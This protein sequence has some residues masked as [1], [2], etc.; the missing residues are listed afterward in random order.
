MWLALPDNDSKARNRRIY[1]QI[2]ELILR[3]DLK[4]GDRLPSTRA[5]G[6]ELGVARGT[7]V[8]AYEQLLAEGFLEAR[9]GSGT[10]VAQ[11]VG[12]PP[13]GNEPPSRKKQPPLPPTPL[14]TATPPQTNAPHAV[15]FRS[16]IP[17]LEHFPVGEWGRLYRQVCDRLPAAALRYSDPCGV[18]E[19]R[20]ALAGWLLRMRGLRAEPERIM[21]TTGATQGLGLVARLLRRPHGEV[22]VE[23]PVHTGLVEVISRAGFAVRGIPVDARGMRADLLRELPTQ[24]A[25]HCAF[26]YVTPSHQYPTGGILPADRRQALVHFVRRQGCMLVEDD[27]DGEFRFEGAPVGAMRELA[28]DAVIYLGSFSKILAPALRLGFAVVPPELAAPWTEAKQYTDVHTDAL[29][30]RTLAAFIKS[31]AL[32]RHIW[33]MRKLYKHKRLCLLESLQ[34][35]FGN[36]FTVSGQA[37]GLH[38]VAAF[39]GV[40]FTDAVLANMRARG[41][42]AVPVERHSLRRDGAHAHELI[43]GYAHLSERE[44][45]RGVC[46]LRDAV[47]K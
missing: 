12:A 43:L 16:G 4:G 13:Q 40:R 19:L 36:G 37:A 2:R 30:Q 38:L 17:A 28:P 26:I 44:M 20:E 29:S 6:K 23:D 42:M 14:L 5:L 11:G 45:E 34:R 7:V 41:V 10:L 33:R 25:R 1:E 18:P 24:T 27:Y 9:R 21:I 39:P 32:E 15:N 3:G 47:S 22:L 8:E 35:H 46:A 31:G